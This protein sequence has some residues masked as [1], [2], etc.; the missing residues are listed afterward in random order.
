MPNPFT[1]KHE[2]PIESALVR[3]IFLGGHEDEV[4]M[5]KVMDQFSET[6]ALPSASYGLLMIGVNAMVYHH[7]TS[8]N[9]KGQRSVVC[10]VP[11]SPFVFVCDEA[12]I[13]AKPFGQQSHDYFVMRMRQQGYEPCKACG[14]AGMVPISDN[15]N[16]L[17]PTMSECLSCEGRGFVLIQ[18]AGPDRPAPAQPPAERTVEDVEFKTKVLKM[19]AETGSSRAECEIALKTWGGDYDQALKWMD[20]CRIKFVS[21]HDP[22]CPGRFG[23]GKPCSPT[24]PQAPF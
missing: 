4:R 20:E 21:S 22:E 17:M 12:A 23:D 24:C 13:R 14:G 5:W 8:E 16:S 3:T 11:N 7:S 1:A 2:P 15:L 10:S 19:I 6:G 9:D 18:A